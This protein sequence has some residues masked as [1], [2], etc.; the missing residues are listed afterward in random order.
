MNGT[1]ALRVARPRSEPS[2]DDADPVSPNAIHM[3]DHSVPG[4]MVATGIT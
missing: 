2:C 4:V 3:N 1:A